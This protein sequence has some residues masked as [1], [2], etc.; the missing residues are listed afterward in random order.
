MKNI[1]LQK[2]PEE[3]EA[4]ITDIQKVKNTLN[5]INIEMD[6]RYDLLKKAHARNIK[7]YNKK[8][9]SR[10]LNPEKGHRYMPYIVVVVDEFCGFDYDC[11]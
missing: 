3:E 5:S 7:E 9:V 10:R 11:G 8:F 2:L 4:I 6:D 1:F